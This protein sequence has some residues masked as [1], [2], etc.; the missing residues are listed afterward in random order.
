MTL[1]TQAFK[2]EES[3]V[4]TLVHNFL[5]FPLKL[6]KNS[7]I[8]KKLFNSLKWFK[9][10]DWW[11]ESPNIWT[12]KISYSLRNHRSGIQ[13]KEHIAGFLFSSNIQA[14]RSCK[15]FTQFR[16]ARKPSFY[17]RGHK[18]IAA[19]KLHFGYFVPDSEICQRFHPETCVHPKG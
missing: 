11:L 7:S 8:S 13:S 9:I 18:C 16:R 15:G 5:L 17:S 19:F 10:I 2:R 3:K 4:N 1:K 14:D 6:Q 12:Q